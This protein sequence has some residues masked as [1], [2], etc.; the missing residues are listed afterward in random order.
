MGAKSSCV[1]LPKKNL[2]EHQRNDGRTRR[3]RHM[4]TQ[5]QGAARARTR[6]AGQ[7][8]ES[9]LRQRSGVRFSGL[10]PVAHAAAVKRRGCW[11]T[12]KTHESA[13]RSAAAAGHRAPLATRQKQHVK[14]P[15]GYDD[16]S[17]TKSRDNSNTTSFRVATTPTASTARGRAARRPAGHKAS[18]ET[19]T[20]GTE[21]A[22]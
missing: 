16:S 5:G 18:G 1:G 20:L 22:R 4:E 3:R 15:P 9:H 11:R 17:A 10:V 2:P 6:R 12:A 8:D 19:C 14:R 21:L 13:E 7:R